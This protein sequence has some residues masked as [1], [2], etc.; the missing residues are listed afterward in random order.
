M[1]SEQID[2]YVYLCGG[3]DRREQMLLQ[4][5]FKLSTTRSKVY[6]LW[7]EEDISDENLPTL[8][9]VNDTEA[10]WNEYRETLDNFGLEEAVTL[11]IGE[12]ESCELAN[13]VANAH[14][15]RPILVSRLLSSL[16]SLVIQEMHSI[17][18]G[19]I[20]D[21]HSLDP[22]QL[23]RISEQAGEAVLNGPSR[24]RIL[25]VDDSNSVRTM[26]GVQ[27][28]MRG[29]LVE[30]AEDGENALT[31]VRDKQY[32][33]IFLDVMLPGMDGYEAC[34]LM[35]KQLKVEQPVVMLTS[36]SG[37]IDKLRGTLSSCDGY[38]TKPL[39]NDEL[40][41]ALEKYLPE[42]VMQ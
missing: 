12:K 37:S 1:N 24:G 15:C 6:H 14:Y 8:F 29:Y 35:K 11:S 9:L 26:M 30:F 27:L 41:E 42:A 34:R 22:E 38:L 23:A 4:G 17:P 13:S 2:I 31:M 7:Q 33:L 3:F 16:D 19:V 18:E 40:S 32:D 39:S 5:A 25:V 20:S 28:A 10:G 21:Q 36:R